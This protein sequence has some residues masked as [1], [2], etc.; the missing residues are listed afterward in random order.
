MSSLKKEKIKIHSE[1]LCKGCQYTKKIGYYFP[2]YVVELT[3]KINQLDDAR[4]KEI[5]EVELE[6]KKGKNVSY[7]NLEIQNIK[8]NYDFLINS[9]SD[10]YFCY[11]LQKK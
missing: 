11:H 10:G 3:Q 9:I 1:C 4:D 5:K 8:K 6:I 2:D 7:L